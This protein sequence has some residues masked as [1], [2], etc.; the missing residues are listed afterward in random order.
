MSSLSLQPAQ[1]CLVT[2]LWAVLG[3]DGNQEIPQALSTPAAA[4]A[5]SLQSC[6]TLCDPRDS[7][8]SGS[9]VTGILQIRTLE[10]VPS[11]MYEGEK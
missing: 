1:S 2:H 6:P 10:W 11:P 5:E 7:S 9:P 4:A 8:P 3:W